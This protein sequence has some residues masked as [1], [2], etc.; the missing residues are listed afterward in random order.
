MFLDNGD[1][2][3]DW[4]CERDFW[5]LFLPVVLFDAGRFRVVLVRRDVVLN[6]FG[7]VSSD[8]RMGVHD[9]LHVDENEQLKKIKSDNYRGARLAGRLLAKLTW[10]HTQAAT[11]N[12]TQKNNN[13][14]CRE[15]SRICINSRDAHGTAITPT[16]HFDNILIENSLSISH[17]DTWVAVTIAKDASLKVGCDLVEQGSVTKGIRQTFFCENESKFADSSPDKNINEQIWSV[18]EAVY[19]VASNNKPFD[20][21]NLRTEKIA[22][23][24]FNCTDTKSP[25]RQTILARTTNINNIIL[26]IAA[27]EIKK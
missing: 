10:L 1:S 25:N 21:L 23:G 15:F 24:R 13:E 22:D 12:I 11:E 27:A 6:F 8:L 16:I 20:P 5:L 9:F 2:L 4:S 17:T 26:T 19:K 3:F 14:I 18:K 7:S